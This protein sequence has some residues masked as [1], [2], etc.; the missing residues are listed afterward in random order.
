M[1][2]RKR[3]PSFK[4]LTAKRSKLVDTITALLKQ[5]IVRGSIRVQGNRCG[6]SKNCKCKRKVDPV[7]HGPYPYLSFRGAKSNHSILLGKSKKE[8][9]EKAVDNHKKVM[10]T[11]IG[12]SEID[13]QILRYHS[14]KLNQTKAKDGKEKV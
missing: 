9:A 3:K 4:R 1:K 7:L 8:Y 6:G 13:F 11:I 12:L 14:D 5:N 2:K 10:E